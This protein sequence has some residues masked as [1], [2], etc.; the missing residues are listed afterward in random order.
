MSKTTKKKYV[1]QEVLNEF[2]IPEPP[3][4]IVKVRF[5]FFMMNVGSSLHRFRLTSALISCY[6][7]QT[8]VLNHEKASLDLRLI[9]T[10][11]ILAVKPGQAQMT[12]LKTIFKHNITSLANAKFISV[13]FFAQ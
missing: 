4:Q 10:A 1:T 13:A 12:D 2:A 3:E 8:T 5:C 9:P 11:V 6:R 7:R